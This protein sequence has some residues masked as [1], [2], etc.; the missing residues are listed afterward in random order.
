MAATRGPLSRSRSTV[1]GAAAGLFG[2]GHV[3]RVG[4]AEPDRGEPPA[5]RRRPARASSLAAVDAVAR[6]RLAARA[7]WPSCS[8]ALRPMLA[9]TT[10]VAWPSCSRRY[11]SRT[12]TR[13]RRPAPRRPHR[14]RC[15]RRWR[16][17][18]SHPRRSSCHRRGGDRLAG[19]VDRAGRRA[20]GRGLVGPSGV[21]RAPSPARGAPAPHRHHRSVRRSRAVAAVR[22][23]GADRPPALRCGAGDVAV[24]TVARPAADAP[25]PS[26][27]GGQ[28]GVAGSP[29]GRGPGGHAS[30]AGA[31][32][33]SRRCRPSCGRSRPSG[34]APR[35][36]SASKRWREP[37]RPS[38]PSCGPPI[39]QK[40]PRARCRIGCGCSRPASTRR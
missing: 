11:P 37:R 39:E 9:H 36:R 22:P 16:V 38:P 26:V 18:P 19:S 8:N 28:R 2:V 27:G 33:R 5:D 40:R 34:S 20:R 23:A 30:P 32:H 21:R 15:R 3:G 29:A 6:A 35:R 12:G 4:L 13:C 10:A 7:R 24:R 31:S 25:A 1:V 14:P 17:R